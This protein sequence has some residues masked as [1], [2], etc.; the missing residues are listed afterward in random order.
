MLTA[1]GFRIASIEPK[2]R[3][4]NEDGDLPGVRQPFAIGRLAALP[5]LR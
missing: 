4:D 5:R 3:Q 1:V 2:S